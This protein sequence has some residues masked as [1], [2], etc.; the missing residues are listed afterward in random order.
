MKGVEDDV[1]FI[2]NGIVREYNNSKN[3]QLT[4]SSII[5]INPNFDE[6]KQYVT[7]YYT[8][9]GIQTVELKKSIFYSL[10]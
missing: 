10:K 8:I 5:V 3:L 4:N 7:F 2:K 6:T 9:I 1:I